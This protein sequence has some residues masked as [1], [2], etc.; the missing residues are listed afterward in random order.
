[1]QGADLSE[2]QKAHMARGEEFEGKLKSTLQNNVFVLENGEPCERIARVRESIAKDA[3]HF[4]VYHPRFHVP[5]E[6]KNWVRA[7]AAAVNVRDYECM[8][9]VS[10]SRCAHTHQVPEHVDFG[11]CEPDFLRVDFNG[12]TARW[13][14]Y[15]MQRQSVY[16]RSALLAARFSLL[17]AHQRELVDLRRWV[18]FP[19]CVSRSSTPRAARTPRWATRHNVHSTTWCCRARL[20]R[21]QRRAHGRWM[22]RLRSGCRCQLARRR[23]RRKRQRRR[24]RH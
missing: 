14:C 11:L 9:K 1:M 23:T 2:L 6:L 24:Q 16:A 7:G 3:G 4:F 19:R 5:D 22:A 20:W 21:V 15:V 8:T 12:D 18:I 10:L 13:R 17:A